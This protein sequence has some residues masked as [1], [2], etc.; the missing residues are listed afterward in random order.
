MPITPL[1]SGLYHH[2]I[3]NPE[4]G[5]LKLTSEK[6]KAICNNL[7]STTEKLDNTSDLLARLTHE[8][9]AIKV[10]RE[11]RQ[12]YKAGLGSTN[13]AYLPE[14]ASPEMS[15]T[16][17]IKSSKNKHLHYLHNHYLGNIRSRN[18]Q[19]IKL[20]QSV[21]DSSPLKIDVGNCG[22]LA[23]AAAKKAIEY[24]GHAERWC[25]PKDD[26]AF[27]IIGKP[28]ESV[29]TDFK[30]WIDCWIVDP[31]ANIV[32][33]APEYV[34]ILKNKMAL[35]AIKGKVIVNLFYDDDRFKWES[36]DNPKWIKSIESGEKI[37]RAAP[38]PD[39][40]NPWAYFSASLGDKKPSLLQENQSFL[41]HRYRNN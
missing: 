27:T 38:S 31:W 5:T 9:I 36:P 4:P 41:H 15:E 26:H 28:P 3:R 32:C 11:V 20:K 2:P 16:A 25:F 37:R 39:N 21:T 29:T 17:R 19:A 34:S 14:M 8:E 18:S 40:K 12:A 22:E 10:A 1:S 7:R 30:T 6:Y 33:K 35:W 13:K 23:N 24:G